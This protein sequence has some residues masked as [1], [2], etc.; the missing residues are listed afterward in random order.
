MIDYVENLKNLR[1][2]FRPEEVIDYES[3]VTLAGSIIV[4]D[5]YDK[6]KEELFHTI[7]ILVLVYGLDEQMAVTKY[8]FDPNNID[9]G[10]IDM[11]K[12]LVV[13][14]YDDMVASSEFDL[15]DKTKET[16]YIVLNAMQNSDLSQYVP[17]E[18]SNFEEKRDGMIIDNSP[19]HFIEPTN[20]LFAKNKV[21]NPNMDK[22][23]CELDKNR[24]GIRTSKPEKDPV[25]SGCGK[26][27][28]S[29]DFIKTTNL[30]DDLDFNQF[31]WDYLREYIIRNNLLPYKCDCCGI[32][33]WQNKILPLIL[34]KKDVMKCNDISNLKFLCPNCN[35]QIGN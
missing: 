11:W 35:S 21:F 9:F 16:Y 5:D 10:N 22:H 27:T 8:T 12:Y 23:E 29:D 32:S 1:F 34:V 6:Y 7:Q 4:S 24:M 20:E 26:P 31:N 15:D 14:L 30:Q 17:E 18:P 19:Y 28:F 25:F 2:N 13:L 33:E 3:L